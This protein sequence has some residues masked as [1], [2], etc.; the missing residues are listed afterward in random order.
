MLGTPNCRI[1]FG[2]E[3][4][5]DNVVVDDR[6]LEI[7]WKSRRHETE[8]VLKLPRLWLMTSPPRG[9]WQRW[10]FACTVR[11]RRNLDKHREQQSPGTEATATSPRSSQTSNLQ[12]ALMHLSSVIMSRD[13]FKSTPGLPQSDSDSPLSVPRILTW[14]PK[15]GCLRSQQKKNQFLSFEPRWR[16]MKIK[17]ASCVCY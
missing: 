4:V 8:S 5:H 6:V 7:A 15:A 2:I 16:E 17:C 3:R 14:R 9:T 1:I 11:K 13:K 12:W 10:L